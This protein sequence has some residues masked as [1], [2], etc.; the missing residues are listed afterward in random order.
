MFGAFEIVI[1]LMMLPVRA[2]S[3]IAGRGV[4]WA[5]MLPLRILGLTARLVGLLFV[6]GVIA[7]LVAGVFYLITAA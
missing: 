6:F 4:V 5:F 2:I 7:L 1:L 3:A